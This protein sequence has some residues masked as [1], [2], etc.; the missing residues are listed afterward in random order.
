MKKNEKHNDLLNALD[1][2][3]SV[4][5]TSQFEIRSICFREK[6]LKQFI[7]TTTKNRRK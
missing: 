4:L 7:E 5:E 3:D 1:G 2:L 6:E